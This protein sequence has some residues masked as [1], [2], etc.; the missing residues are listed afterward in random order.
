V[1]GGRARAAALD[2]RGGLCFEPGK[3][4]KCGICVRVAERAGDHPGLAFSG[5][6]FDLRVTV[7]FNE[8][9]RT[10]LPA[11]ARE[12]AARCPTGALVWEP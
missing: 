5:R 1:V 2:G 3:C 12:C 10:A 4:I 8:G 11:T 7:P 6:G 9:L